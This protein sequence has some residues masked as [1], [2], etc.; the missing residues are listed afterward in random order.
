MF[1][2][3]YN[4]TVDTKGRVSL[5]VKF[6][7]ALGDVF[8]ITKGMENCLFIYDRTEWENMDEKLKKLRLTQKAARGFS[9]L[10]YSGA[11]EL[12]SDKQGRIVIP[13]HLRG[14][15]GID[16]DVVLIGVSNRIE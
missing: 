2:G 6:R 7:E 11:M 3:E 5:P 13:P 4:H 1:I 10:F 8:Y 16:K 9:R 12:E 15:A 14:Y